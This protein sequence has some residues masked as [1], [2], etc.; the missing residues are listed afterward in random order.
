MRTILLVTRLHGRHM[1]RGRSKN[2]ALEFR[3]KIESGQ[4]A[5][6]QRLP[7]TRELAAKYQVSA[8]TIQ[9]AFRFL[10]AHGLVDRRPRR[11]G[12]VKQPARRPQSRATTVAFVGLFGDG[13]HASDISEWTQR[14]V[15]GADQELVQSG[16]HPSL[17]SYSSEGAHEV[18][19]LLAKI[20]QAAETLAGV[21]L[22]LSPPIYGLG[23]ELDKRQIPWVAINR[24]REHAAH[25]FVMHDAFKGARLIGRCLARM[26]TPRIVVLSDPMRP[27]KSSADKFFGLIQGYVERGMPLRNIDFVGSEGYL[28]QDGYSLLKGYLSQHGL[29]GVVFTSGDLLAVGALRLLRE[30]GISVPSQVGVIGATGLKLAQYM[31]PSLTVLA[32]PMERMGQEAARMLLEMSREQVTR[33]TGRYVPAPVIVRE[34]CAIPQE[35]LEAEKKELF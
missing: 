35:L 15:R 5:L 30:E 22:F 23:E 9:S 20:E 3:R 6:G 32:T 19:R 7:T 28:E 8:N 27:G 16:Y 24:P 14:I 33:L 4:W 29:P 18:P 17:F 34:S 2:L 25:N 21:V 1:N 31:H 11:G 12:F 10:E 13:A 26:K